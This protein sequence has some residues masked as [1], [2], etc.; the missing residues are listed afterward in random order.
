MDL[1]ALL[2]LVPEQYRAALQEVIIQIVSRYALPEVNALALA[3]DL[4]ALKR[5][6]SSPLASPEPSACVDSLSAYEVLR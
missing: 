4:E 6:A 5:W 1:A 2:A 3:A